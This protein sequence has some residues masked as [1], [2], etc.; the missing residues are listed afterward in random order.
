ML[1]HWWHSA[2]LGDEPLLLTL[3]RGHPNRHLLWPVEKGAW[4]GVGEGRMPGRWMLYHHWP[5]CPPLLGYSPIAEPS[6]MGGTEQGCSPTP[7]ELPLPLWGCRQAW[8]AH[9]MRSGACP[10]FAGKPPPAGLIAVQGVLRS[11]PC[12]CR[13]LESLLIP[14]HPAWP[15]GQ[16][17]ITRGASRAGSPGITPRCQLSACAAPRTPGT[18]FI[19]EMG[20]QRKT[21]H[22][23][24]GLTS[25]WGQDVG[26][27]GVQLRDML[28]WWG[29]ERGESHWYPGLVPH[30]APSGATSLS[31]SASGAIRWPVAGTARSAPC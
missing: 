18:M 2:G 28:G 13:S 8:L 25:Q 23:R 30:P 20:N 26:C 17:V 27:G 3:S 6:R 4:A 9:G 22:Q 10:R 16:V 12:R 31:L 5:C 19:P 7:C 29:K 15:C 24:P 21:S 11:L 14:G 1:L